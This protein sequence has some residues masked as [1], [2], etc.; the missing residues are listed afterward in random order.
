MYFLEIKATKESRILLCD[1][2]K[3]FDSLPRLA[4]WATLRH[5]GCTLHKRVQAL[6]DGMTLRLHQY[7]SKAGLSLCIFMVLVS[8]MVTPLTQ[9][10][11]RLQGTHASFGG[12]LQTLSLNHDLNLQNKILVFIAIVL[13]SLLSAS[14]RSKDR[15]NKHD[16]RAKVQGSITVNVFMQLRV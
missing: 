7:W 15:N 3:A 6:Y 5:F 1:L 10:R 14:R 8:S 11:P 13:T 12:N 2:E 9:G 4:M 16:F